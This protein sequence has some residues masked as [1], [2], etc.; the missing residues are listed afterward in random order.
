MYAGKDERESSDRISEVFEVLEL[1]KKAEQVAAA[2]EASQ[3]VS[4][5]DSIHYETRI[6]NRS[7]S[8]PKTEGHAKL[9]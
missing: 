3:A 9:E 2:W 6:S 7:Q 8:I 5:S 1:T 4:P